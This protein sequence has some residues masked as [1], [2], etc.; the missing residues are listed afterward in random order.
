MSCP[1]LAPAAWAKAK[2]V[3]RGDSTKAVS[4]KAAALAAGITLGELNAWVAR[5][6]ERN[7]DDEEWVHE[8]AVVYDQRFNDQAATLEDV[9]WNHAVD[10]VDHP[11]V[12]KGEITDT[13]KKFDHRLQLT[14]LKRRDPNYQKPPELHLHGHV[15]LDGHEIGKRLEALERLK[16]AHDTE[17]LEV[18]NV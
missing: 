16:L 15:R 2:A 9:M 13:F 5:S 7:E 6:R 18:L 8:I 3:L 4:P 11:V 14:M 10:G 1:N 17:D 12:H